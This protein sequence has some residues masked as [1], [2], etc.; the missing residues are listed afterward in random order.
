MQAG[1]AWALLRADGEGYTIEAGCDTTG[2]VERMY[3]VHDLLTSRWLPQAHSY[4]T[5][6]REGSFQQDQQMSLNGEDFVV[7]RSQKYPEGW[8]SQEDHYNGEAT[9]E[10]PVSA[11]YRLRN[12]ALLPGG[13][14]VF[15][16]FTGRRTVNL[17]AHI[18]KECEISGKRVLKVDVSTAHNGDMQGKLT[19]FISA[20]ENRLPVQVVVQTR[21]G[22]VYATLIKRTFAH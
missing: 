14:V 4:S 15:P 8:R 9:V 16:L 20:D 18:G 5:R 17:V 2:V 11:F 12:E 7:K 6:F 19:V 3:S 1:I 21:A 13:T 10:D 22:P